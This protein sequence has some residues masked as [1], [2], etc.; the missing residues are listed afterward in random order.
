MNILNITDYILELYEGRQKDFGPRAEVVKRIIERNKQAI[1][2]S[3]RQ[4]AQLSPDQPSGDV[5]MTVGT[6]G[7][8]PKERGK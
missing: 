5:K 3:A 7:W 8:S 1:S 6:A 2:G 4:P